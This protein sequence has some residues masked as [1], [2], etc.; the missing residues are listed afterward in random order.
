MSHQYVKQLVHIMWSTH[1]QKPYISEAFQNDLYAYITSLVKSKNG[2][3]I[4]IGGSC[5]HVHVLTTIPPDVSIV[6]MV[7][8]LKA[9]SSK[10]A[11]KSMVAHPQFGWQ[12]GF[13]AISTQDDK[14][15]NVCRYI[16]A[17]KLNHA[18]KSYEEELKFILKQQ[19]I[20]YIDKY[21][22]QDSYSK[23]FVHM[24]WATENRKPLLEKSI[25][26]ELHQQF[27]SIISRL[28]GVV[29]EI[30]GI[31]D[32]IHLLIEAPKSIALSD[33]IREVKTGM[34]HWIKAGNNSKFRHSD[35]AWQMGYGAFSVSYSGVE[36]VKHYIQG[37][38]VH[39]R[40]QSSDDEWNS[41]LLKNGCLMRS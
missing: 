24:V 29:H 4:V 31:E 15:D 41:F 28:G 27:N 37:Q 13:L 20:D 9:Y 7:S 11:K 32:H 1:E 2:N 26:P 39:H 40:K 23:V 30:G 38:E 5:D 18:S 34:T 10:W 21:V 16:R 17:D 33:L 36:G 22:L 25:Q 8:H 12:K 3:I 35:F 19:D 14:I 6:S